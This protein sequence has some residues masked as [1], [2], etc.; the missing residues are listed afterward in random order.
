MINI[1][2]YIIEKLHLDKDISVSNSDKVT[3]DEIV[4]DTWKDV[5]KFIKKYLPDFDGWKYYIYYNIKTKGEKYQGDDTHLLINFVYSFPEKLVR[6]EIQ[7]KMK[8]DIVKIKTKD[9]KQLFN[10]EIDI[11]N[12]KQSI[13]LYFNQ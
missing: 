6:R 8:E 7:E 9:G 13:R 5:Y 10:G 4:D 1:N 3:D 11:N 2:K 12:I